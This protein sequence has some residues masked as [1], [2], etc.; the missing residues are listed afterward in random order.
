MLFICKIKS[1]LKIFFLKKNRND[2]TFWMTTGLY[3]QS[4]VITFPQ[5]VEIK[6]M[7]LLSLGVKYIVIEKSSSGHPV[8]FDLISEKSKF[9]FYNKKKNNTLF[10]LFIL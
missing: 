6:G 10:I 8:E 4:A 9:I 1:I 7:Q 2:G 5:Q 3:P